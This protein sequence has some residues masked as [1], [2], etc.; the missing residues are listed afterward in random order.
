MMINV[1]DKDVDQLRDKKV[2]PRQYCSHKPI[3]KQT[4]ICDDDNCVKE[5]TNVLMMLMLKKPTLVNI[6]A[7]N[8]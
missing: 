2:N 1:E 8:L 7:T 3:E 5:W 4:N 6:A